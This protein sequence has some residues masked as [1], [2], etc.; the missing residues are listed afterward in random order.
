MSNALSRGKKKMRPLGYS[1]QELVSMQN[2]AKRKGNADSLIEESYFNIRLITYQI[3]HDKFGFGLK[4]INRVEQVISK[5]LEDAGSGTLST[6]EL[7][8]YLYIESGISARQEANKVP[9]RERFS[10]VERKVAPA[11]MQAAGDFLLV[12]IYTHFALLGVCLKT[13]FKFSKRQIS[14]VFGWIRYYINSLATGYETML[15]VASVLACECKYYDPRF[16]GK[17]YEV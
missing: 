14:E 3:L 1:K 15:G 7:E 13:K 8:H 12:S 17:T 6:E 11:S 9:F 10:L 4:R 2:Y 5:Y 16:I